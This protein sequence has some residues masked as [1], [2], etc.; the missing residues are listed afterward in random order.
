MPIEAYGDT[1]IQRPIEEV[2]DYGSDPCSEPNSN[3]LRRALER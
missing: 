3:H 1:T 2:F